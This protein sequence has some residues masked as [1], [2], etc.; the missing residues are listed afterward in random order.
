[1]ENTGMSF[2]VYLSAAEGLLIVCMLG[3]EVFWLRRMY[4]VLQRMPTSEQIGEMVSMIRSD[5]DGIKQA[6]NALVSTIDP[7]KSM[8]SSLNIGGLFGISNKKE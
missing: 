6:F 1:M 3:W 4:Q 5:R 8:L 2:F 7:L